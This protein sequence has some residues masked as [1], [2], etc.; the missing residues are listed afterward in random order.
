[1]H[2]SNKTPRL[3]RVF[4]TCSFSIGEH[5]SCDTRCSML[6][7]SIC[8][9]SPTVIHF[10]KDANSFSLR[11]IFR[12]QFLGPRCTLC[13][14]ALSKDRV[15]N[16]HGT[17]NPIVFLPNS[18]HNCSSF[19]STVRPWLP[20]TSIFIY[21]ILQ[22]IQNSFR[23]VIP[24]LT[25]QYKQTDQDWFAAL[26]LSLNEGRYNQNTICNFTCM[27]FIVFPSVDLLIW[28]NASVLGFHRFLL[29]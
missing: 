25:P 1:M 11:M 2:L 26:Y 23:I 3:A 16:A 7:L 14:C 28:N 5:L 27:G 20:T 18:F 13:F 21:S 17:V 29:I 6:I 8:G 19:S 9:T 15:R 24:V 10:S 12:N 22:Y 4:L